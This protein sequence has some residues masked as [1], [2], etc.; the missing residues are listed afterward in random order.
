MKKEEELENDNK[1]FNSNNYNTLQIGNSKDIYEDNDKETD[2]ILTKLDN[3]SENSDKSFDSPIIFNRTKTFYRPLKTEARE[4]LSKSIIVGKKI[5]NK[6][7]HNNCLSNILNKSYT[8]KNNNIFRKQ[9]RTQFKT[10]FRTKS[11]MNM[12]TKCSIR[13]KKVFNFSKKLKKIECEDTIPELFQNHSHVNI[14]N[15]NN[16]AKINDNINDDINNN[17]LITYNYDNINDM[18]DNIIITNDNVNYNVLPSIS[19]KV[20]DNLNKENKDNKIGV[21][22][23]NEKMENIITLM[24]DM[25]E[26]DKR[27][28]KKDFNNL[29]NNYLLNISEL[30][31]Q[32]KNINLNDFYE[33]INELFDFIIELLLS[34]QNHN[35]KTNNKVGNEKI[36]LKLQNELKEKNKEIGE[37]MNKMNFQKDKLNNS[38]KSSNTEMLN[39]RKMNKELTS[40]LLNAQK[41]ITRLE[42]NNNTL[43]EKLN[44]VIIDKTSK[45]IAPSISVKS[46]FIGTIPKMEPISLDSSMMTQKFV[47]PNENNRN[48]NQKLNDKYNIA[49]KLN[50]N[51]IDLLKEI[52]NMLLYYDS[53]LNKECGGN[54]NLSNVAKNMISFLDINALIDDKK[55]KTVSNDFM[56]NMDKIYKKIEEYIKEVNNNNSQTKNAYTTYN[57][58]SY[59]V[60]VKKDKKMSAFKE[61]NKNSI[62]KR[63]INNSI[64]SIRNHK[65][66]NNFQATRKRTNT[67]NVPKKKDG[68]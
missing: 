38:F 14:L 25:K 29:L 18:N 61:Y 53:F 44:K 65:N 64:N 67:I 5:N 23:L 15:Y 3:L 28:K 39:L 9:F 46:T 51:L 24:K 48:N 49:K 6:N 2:D 12:K 56:R 35:M 37:L 58:S 30:E 47:S 13:N 50:L 57:S 40:K 32:Q 26:I 21:G 22:M 19:E 4:V 33:P 34:I 68:I 45:S 7:R 1:D 54:K 52:N 63:N 31:K 66:V 17:N 10:Q 42:T 59:K 27:L 11:L 36:I 8:S 16:L 41:Q 55:M 62:D 60:V 20:N 43:E